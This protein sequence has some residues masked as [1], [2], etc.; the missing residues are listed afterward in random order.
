[1][2]ELNFVSTEE[3]LDEIFA[4]F[5]HCIFAGVKP[6]RDDCITKRR[7]KGDSTTCLGICTLIEKL[8]L[9]SWRKEQ[10]DLTADVEEI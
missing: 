5:D 7:Y 9:D 10:K 3:L 6:H 4:R 8:I 1:M 2:N